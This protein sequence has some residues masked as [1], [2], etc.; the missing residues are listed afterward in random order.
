DRLSQRG[1]FAVQ[2]GLAA[3]WESWGI[4]PS[5]VMGHSVGEVAASYVAGALS[6][7]DAVHVCYHRSRLQHQTRGQGKLLA[8]GLSLDD[9][10]RLLLPHEGQV[11]I[12]AINGP[13]SITLSG[14]ADAL[15]EIHDE[16]T[17]EGTFS[18]VLQ[19]DVPYHS[20]K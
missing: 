19:V 17:V 3:L 9:T 1:I 6:F 10:R 2:V 16:L 14:D 20:A 7:E 5:M 13:Q 12:A 4:K 18:R 8:I 11:S 15:A